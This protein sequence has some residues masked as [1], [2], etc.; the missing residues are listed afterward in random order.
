MNNKTRRIQVKQFCLALLAAG[1]VTLY[2][3]GGGGGSSSA[4]S[5]IT[6]V[7]ATG[8]PFSAREAYDWGMVNKLC[9]PGKLMDDALETARAIVRNAPIS[10]QMIKKAINTG[11]QTDLTSGLTIEIAAYNRTVT[12]QDRLEGVLAFNEKR[13]PAFK[14]R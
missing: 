11:T 2:G 8:K 9:E 4:T 6:C 14:G 1:M 7:A 5:T 10:V 12:T 3:C 13:P